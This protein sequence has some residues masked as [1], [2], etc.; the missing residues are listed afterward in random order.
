MF[1]LFLGMLF[2]VI[3]AVNI[4]QSKDLSDY[5]L[6]KDV[7]EAMSGDWRAQIFHCN[8][9]K[10]TDADGNTHFYPAKDIDGRITKLNKVLNGTN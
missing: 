8:S 2:T 7:I 10:L 6:K 9:E 4:Y 3:G 1:Y 5:V